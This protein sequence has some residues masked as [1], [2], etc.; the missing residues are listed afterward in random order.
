MERASQVAN[1]LH[2]AIALLGLLALTSLSGCTVVTVVGAGVS[3]AA[4]GVETA[5]TVAGTAV[6]TTAKVG[7]AVIDAMIP[8]SDKEEEKK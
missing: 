7:S 1:R 2:K 4:T 8:D 5:V 3:I 6:S